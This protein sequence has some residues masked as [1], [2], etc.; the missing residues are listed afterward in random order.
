MPS[1]ATRSPASLFRSEPGG[2]PGSTP[3]VGRYSL[4]TRLNAKQRGILLATAVLLLGCELFP[5]W[6]YEYEYIPTF[7]HFCPAGYAFFTRPP[8]VRSSDE[9]L[10]ICKTSEVPLSAVVTRP[11]GGRW[12]YQTAVIGVSATGLF[13]AFR[14][15]QNAF[16]WLAATVLVLIGILGCLGLFL[17]VP[18]M[19]S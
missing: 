4:M 19:Y 6:R 18:L 7:T 9:M 14:A 16:T 2:N 1:T 10:S 13:L 5:P 8:A 3:N 17:I 15:R 12:I 11:D